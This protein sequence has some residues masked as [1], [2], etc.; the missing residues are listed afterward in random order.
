MKTVL[1]TFGVI[2]TGLFAAS[3]ASATITFETQWDTGLTNDEADMATGPDGTILLLSPRRQRV[4][5]FSSDGE[6]LDTWRITS[7]ESEALAVTPDGVVLVSSA[8]RVE[9][10]TAKGERLKTWHID[11]NLGDNSLG[12]SLSHGISVAPSGEVYL[13]DPFNFQVLRFSPT[14]EYL[15]Y[16]GGFS[17]EYLYS[18]DE[19]AFG[20]D[21]RLFASEDPG[22]KIHVF[23]PKGRFIESWGREGAG[24]GEFLTTSVIAT[25]G[26]G[27]VYADDGLL[28]RVQV[29]A[30][31]GKFLD[32]VGSAGAGPGRFRFIDSI[33]TGADGEF[34]VLD[35]RGARIQKLTYEDGPHVPQAQIYLSSSFMV[36]ALPGKRAKVALGVSNFGDQSALNVRVCPVRNRG[37]KRDFVRK[38]LRGQ[39]CRTFDSIAPGQ[40]RGFEIRPRIPANTR[41]DKFHFVLFKQTSSGAG[42]SRTPVYIYTGRSLKWFEDFSLRKRQSVAMRLRASGAPGT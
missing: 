11:P 13:T 24:P 32:Q 18:L 17:S 30:A 34:F 4:I 29:F 21:G 15:G 35:R 6:R 39:K 42:G 3:S 36:N 7:R 40:T 20:P 2:L 37:R 26:V 19:V 14:G 28:S 25:D 31:D 9:R 1:L 10:F 27:R 16:F 38:F 33:A 8:D 5:E 22:D 41:K 12:E 23:G